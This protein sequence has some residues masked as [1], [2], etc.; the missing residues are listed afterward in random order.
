MCLSPLPPLAWY[1][2]HSPFQ[3]PKI[4][5]ISGCPSPK[6]TTSLYANTCARRYYATAEVTQTRPL[7]A[8]NPP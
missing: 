3:A 8:P 7:R 4:I 5:Q 2:S 6:V 1:F